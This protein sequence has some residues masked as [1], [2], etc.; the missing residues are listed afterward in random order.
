MKYDQA[1]LIDYLKSRLATT[2]RDCILQLA[3]HLQRSV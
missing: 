2:S 3:Y 1:A